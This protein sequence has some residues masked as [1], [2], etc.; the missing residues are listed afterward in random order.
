MN[1]SDKFSRFDEFNPNQ[2]GFEME[3]QCV[4]CFYSG[5]FGDDETFSRLN[6]RHG[7]PPAYGRATAP[8]LNRTRKPQTT[9]TTATQAVQ[10]NTTTPTANGAVQEKLVEKVQQAAQAQEENQEPNRVGIGLGIAAAI[11]A[12]FLLSE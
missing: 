2:E 9:A 7:N 6:R 5:D 11:G 1:N 12:Y 8:G 10:E 4:Q 3:N